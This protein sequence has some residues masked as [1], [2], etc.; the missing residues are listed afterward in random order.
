MNDTLQLS[1]D[2]SALPLDE[3]DVVEDELTVESL[4]AEK[5]GGGGCCHFC[6]CPC[7]CCV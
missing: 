5:P 2:V 1:L 3:F 6:A 7:V 4:T